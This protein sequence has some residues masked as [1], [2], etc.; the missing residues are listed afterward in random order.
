MRCFIVFFL[1]VVIS[2]GCS[3]AG[4][5]FQTFY[6][7]SSTG[8][9]SNSG[10]SVGAPWATLQPLGGKSL[11]PGDKIL[12][13]AGSIFKGS[14]ILEDCSGT[15]QKPI[16]V[17]SYEDNG[18][19]NLPLIDAYGF[20]DGILIKNCSHIKVSGIEITGN[21]G[22]VV[23]SV[24]PKSNMHCGVLVTVSDAGSYE[25]IQLSDLKIRDLFFEEKGVE[26]G[27]DEVHSANGEQ[28]YGW[29]IRVINQTQGATLKNIR[30]ENCDVENVAHTGIKVT[31]SNKNIEDVT[32]S[33]NIVSY[34]GGP[35]MQMS[36]VSNALVRDNEVQYSGSSND[37]RKWGRG[38][39]FWC[40]GSSDILIEKNSFRKANGPGDSAGCHIDFNCN[41]VVV[42]YNLSEGNAGGFCEI[43]GN[44]YNCSYRYNI[45]I[46][47]GYRVKG[48]EGAFQEGKI[49]WLSGY[50]GSDN[51]RTGPFNSYFYNNT[52]YVSKDIVAKIAVDRASS[53]VLIAN[54][55][56]CFEGESQEVKGDQYSPETGG[57][58]SV[59]RIVF[60]NNLY[61]N[62]ANWPENVLIQDH[63]PFFGNPGYQNPGGLTAEDYIPQN[64]SL[65]RNKG[66]PIEKIPG[67]EL[68]LAIGLEVEKD[69]FG[70]PVKGLPDMGAIEM[71]EN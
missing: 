67:D 43:L 36:G 10:Q 55:I 54:N 48:E 5:D 1:Q 53:G 28:S 45:S 63:D 6:I 40:W 38:S 41:N 68:G 56:F 3:K 61:L 30:I 4:A 17:E 57:E 2:L 32:I 29:G 62:D 7:N 52:I 70:N 59:E 65:I 49:F 47:D 39:G 37:S 34:S 21:G 13:A 19:S 24:N 42:Q 9:D 66:I 22:G 58:S 12:L 51:P 20:T 35:G 23:T 16:I 27:A 64:A 33:K 44:N 26:R 8:S 18:N 25:N 69:F 50:A 31:G 71:S 14:L 15:A 11:D 60:K 46:Y